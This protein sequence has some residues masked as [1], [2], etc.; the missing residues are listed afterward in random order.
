[1]S[2]V[3]AGEAVFVAQTD[4]AGTYGSFTL[5]SDGQW[6]YEADTTQAAIQALGKDETLT[7]SF[8]AATAD[9]TEQTVTVTITGVNDGA[10]IGG[11][12]T[13]DVTEDAAATLAASGALSVTDADTGEAEFVAQT[14][15]AGTYGSF[16]LGTDGQWTYEADNSQAAIQALGKDETLTDSFTATTA[17]GTT[18]TVTVTITGMNDGAVIGGTATGDVTEDE[19]APTL[20]TS[21]TLTVTD[22]DAGEAV[23]VA[24]ANAAGDNGFGSF[25]LD[26]DGKWTYEADTTQAAIQA[27]GAGATLTD[28]FTATTADGTAQA[29]TVTITGENDGAVIG[30]TV[31][32][33]V[34]EDAAATLAASG[35]LSVTDADTGEAEFVA[36]TD[37]AGTYG[38]FTLG[39][40][41]QWTY[42]TDNSQAAIQALGKDERL[43]DSF[44]A[45][46]KDGTE[47][48]VTVTITGV[49]DGAV[50]S[51]ADFAAVPEGDAGISSNTVFDPA[52]IM[53]AS[54][55]D[56][57]ETPRIKAGSLSIAVAA[58]SDTG[59]VT[60][61]DIGATTA[62]VDTANYDF[63]GA[64]ES[65]RFVL[66][67]DV[68]SGEDESR[69]ESVIE[70]TGRNDAPVVQDILVSGNNG[71]PLG[72]TVTATDPDAGDTVSFSPGAQGP[73]NGAVSVND[74]GSF[75]YTPQAGFAGFD[76]FEILASDGTSSDSSTVTLAVDDPGSQVAR[77][78][79]LGI[80]ID[81]ES[82]DGRPAGSV[83]ITRSTVEATPINLV[84]ALDGSGSFADEFD[85]QIAAVKNAL[86]A[87]AEDFS[88]PGAP[89]VDVQII[90]FSTD[91]TSYGRSGVDDP[92]YGF[93]PFDLVADAD[94][95]QEELGKIEHPGG[96]T[97]WGAAIN[98]AKAFFDQEASGGND[99]VDF[100][101]F[102]T[103][104][105]PT[106]ADSLWQTAVR[107]IRDAHDP[108]I[109][110]FGIG[111]GFDPA[112][113]EQTFTIDGVDYQF[114]SDGDAGTINS[115]VDLTAELLSTGLF[116]AELVSFSLELT[117]DGTDHGVIA[118]AINEDGTGFTL[119]LAEIDGIEDML[120]Q[121][122][123]FLATAVFDLDGD[124]GT[125]SDQVT[126]VE[127]GR[128]SAPDAPVSPAGSDGDDLML[129]GAG[130]DTLDGGAGDDLLIGG[131][132]D[133]SLLGGSGD[134]LVVPGAAAVTTLVDGGAGRDTLKF[135][136]AGD[137]TS[138]VLPSLSIH[139]IEVL[140][141]E[142][143]AD[144]TLSLTVTD[145]EGL[146]PGIDT[147]L[148]ILV[149][150]AF[151]NPD[152]GTIRGEG[153]DT[154]A[155]SNPEGTIEQNP[156][157]T[158]PVTDGNGT[159]FD[160][161]Q[162]FDGSH[163]V[164]AT[165]A[166][167]DDVNV[168]MVNA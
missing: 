147:D 148:G 61:F 131:G 17:D 139:E 42:E 11:T 2:D 32:G 38:S 85:D 138:D 48:T 141:M 51:V 115:A 43:T 97:N 101:Y 158:G 125:T 10:V 35:A 110:T 136:S 29:V 105:Q 108:Q 102:I 15:T 89:Q 98:D 132:G 75:T 107:D 113:M 56:T 53:T 157:G 120:G 14:D 127:A 137:L 22:A 114:D 24:Q 50:I 47:Q 73:G 18:E 159:T 40:D 154:L 111:N 150:S 166:V 12:V 122:N 65:G 90:V 134:D 70:I 133:D 99:E 112:K 1:M 71:G 30:G 23:V 69:H 79:G 9:G 156:S 84:F 33:D 118:T 167:D 72:G 130:A 82:I 80:T 19:D 91:A 66:S 106:G 160:I 41:G 37:T 161:Y 60:P 151:P 67:F 58:D 96:V 46:T 140:D 54:D 152:G 145:I 117:S 78:R 94:A 8:T 28:S 49:N 5:G 21:G 45:T 74:D 116:A 31:T 44:T 52:L 149:D 143:G 123:D 6:T 55:V 104:G 135:D 62:T 142:N 81:G 27:L 76:R 95:I 163:T 164:L 87:L 64:G 7:D 39:T 128:L 13:G 86:A 162:F 92:T 124:S 83:N 121:T 59:V 119:P 146:W 126:I 68:I 109:F 168:A 4:T 16:T 93:T 129:G 25:T 144:N 34:T 3:D 153:G 155:L 88:G 165:L 77:D 63:L 100:L 20:T 26:T 57:A 103:D 36:Q